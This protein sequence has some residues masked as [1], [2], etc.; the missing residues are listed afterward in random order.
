MASKFARFEPVEYRVWEIYHEKVFKILITD[1][2]ELKQQL[3]T[4]YA[5]LAHVVAAERK[6][7]MPYS[8]L[9]NVFKGF[10]F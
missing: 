8:L 6:K 10:I 2:D 1:L 9:M 5:K 3:R 7:Q 4:E